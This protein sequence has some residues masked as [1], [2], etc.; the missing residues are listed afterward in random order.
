MRWTVGV[1]ALLSVRRRVPAVRADLASALRLAR[2]RSP[3]PIAEPTNTQE[4]VA[5]AVAV[6]ARPRRHLR[7]LGDLRR[8]SACRR[9]APVTLFEHKFYWDELYDLVWYRTQRPRSRAASTPSS[10]GR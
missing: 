8:R 9:R 3:R 6:V 10:S 7:R 5:S 4:W 1:L 2:R